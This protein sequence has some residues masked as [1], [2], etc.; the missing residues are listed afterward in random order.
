[1]LSGDHHQ[2]GAVGP[3][4][5]LGALVAR[6]PEAVHNLSE[7][8]RQDDPEERQALEALRHGDVAEAGPVV[9]RARPRPR[10]Q[11]RDDALQAAV[12]AWAADVAAGRDTGLY[13]WRRANV[14]ELNLRARAWM[15]DSGRLFGPE[16]P[17][18]GGATY[19][20]GD[21]V[22]TP[23]APDAGAGLVTSER[24]TV[25]S[26]DLATG[27]LLVRTDD[28]RPGGRLSGEEAGAGRF[29]SPLGTPQRSTARRERRRRGLT[30]L[31]TVEG[32]SWP[33]W[34]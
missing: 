19:R 8:R 33:M 9:R 5:A 27:S 6:H 20:A 4:G 1:M 13:A 15:E 2:L 34:P 14:A 21:R 26:V 16:L 28:G 7:N 10:R 24:A 17:C 12:D 22:V 3:G 11:D 18:P 31:P 32:G 30:S 29:L 23:R 25:E